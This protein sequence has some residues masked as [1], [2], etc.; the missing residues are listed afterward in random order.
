M[1]TTKDKAYW[2]LPEHIRHAI[3]ISRKKSKHSEFYGRLTEL[4]DKIGVY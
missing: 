2:A 1:E 4:N 3:D